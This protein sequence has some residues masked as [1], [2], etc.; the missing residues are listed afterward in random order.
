M[1]DR[2]PKLINDYDIKIFKY[3]SHKYF[4]NN[5]IKK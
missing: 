2:I 1:F 3:S 4:V 5:L